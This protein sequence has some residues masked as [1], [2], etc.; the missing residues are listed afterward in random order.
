MKS[1]RPWPAPTWPAA[2]LG[3]AM[4]AGTTTAAHAQ[5]CPDFT[6]GEFGNPIYGSGGSAGRPL[7]GKF[8]TAF[9]NAE[10][11][12]TIVWSD[13]GGA[14]SSLDRLVGITGTPTPISGTVYYWTPEGVATQC[15]IDV[16][17]AVDADFG[18]M[19]Q[20][21][22][23][24]VNYASGIPDTIG[25]EI[26]P[27][28]P[29]VLFVHPN[30]SQT[31]IS[32]EA[33]YV[34]YGRGDQAGLS[35]WNNDLY[36]SR[37]DANSAAQIAIATA[38]G[39]GV[40]QFNGFN[41]LTNQGS[42]NYIAGLGA[43]AS[44]TLGFVSGETYDQPNP[45]GLDNRELVRAL[46]YQHTDQTCGYLPDS[47]LT[48]FDKRNIRD[49]KYWL[50]ANHHFYGYVDEEGEF[51]N[52]DVARFVAAITGQAAPTDEVPNLQLIAQNNTVPECAMNVG[53]DGDYGPLYSY[54]PE[55]P[56]HCYFDRWA[57]GSTECETCDLEDEGQ[58]CG[59]AGT[60]VCRRGYCEAW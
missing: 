38:S 41:T 11:P 21:P 50:W 49:G 36:L 19:A 47:T 34:I 26:G 44:Q 42:I 45:N 28:T 48:S 57:T 4:W 60:S 32:A 7:I 15:T 39:L 2:L 53:R 24:C 29:W 13:A 55:E 1:I 56:C 52:P 37:R 20:E 5:A 54:A 12:I 14:C 8:A 58:P 3:L 59:D 9:R 27:A 30:S 25:N 31:T 51:T 46:A 40:T 43:N 10:E 23:A 33:L 35:P 16:G 22:E 6:S 17:S 18:S